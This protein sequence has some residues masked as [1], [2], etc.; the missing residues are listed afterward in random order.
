[1]ASADKICDINYGHKKGFLKQT[2]AMKNRQ[3]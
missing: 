1:M 3:P 2:E